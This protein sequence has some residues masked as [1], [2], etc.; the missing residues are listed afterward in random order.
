MSLAETL[1]ACPTNCHIRIRK[2]SSTLFL[3]PCSWWRS[4]TTNG[5][6]ESGPTHFEIY[7]DSKLLWRSKAITTRRQ[8]D[9]GVVDVSGVG[10]LELRVGV[11]GADLEPTRSGSTRC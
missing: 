10:T 11:Q 8:L 5:G 6:K 4:T 9:E 3:C 7:G 1:P 2:N